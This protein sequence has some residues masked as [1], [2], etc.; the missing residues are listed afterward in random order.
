MAVMNVAT[1]ATAPQSFDARPDP[2][3]VR[4]SLVT[5]TLDNAHF[6]YEYYY[7][8]LAGGADKQFTYTFSS[9]QRVM[10][11][12]L[13]VQQPLAATDFTLDPLPTIARHD[14]ALG[15]T[16]HQFSVGALAGGE[17]TAVTVS[18]TKTDP[19]PSMSREDVMAMQMQDVP[20]DVPAS[21]MPAA[22]GTS[23]TGGAAPGWPAVLL[24]VV[25][26][27]AGGVVWFRSVSSGDSPAPIASTAPE[28]AQ[29]TAYCSQCGATYKSKAR[30][31]HVCGAARS[32]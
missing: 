31:C 20:S 5:Y 29:S 9:P 12:L 4:W 13:E 15:F 16:Y 24:T 27:S 1:G 21:D 8:P 28:A 26:V 32:G 22:A 14:E 10:E 7:D 30:F 2:D 3:D 6:F 23:Q 17:E 11:L 18:Y 25:L 19:K